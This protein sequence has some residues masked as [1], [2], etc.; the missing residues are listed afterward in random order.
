MTDTTDTTN[1]LRAA[2]EALTNEAKRRVDAY[3]GVVRRHIRGEVTLMEREFAWGAAMDAI[4]AI[5]A[6]E[7]PAEKHCPSAQ[8]PAPSAPEQPANVSAKKPSHLQQWRSVIEHGEIYRDDQQAP[9]QPND[10]DVI[11]PNCTHQF[12]AIPEQVQRLML[13][14]GFEPPFTAAPK[15]PSAAAPQT[16]SFVQPVPDKCDRITW[17]GRYYHLPLATSAA[18]VPVSGLK[19]AV[20][21]VKHFGNPIPQ[22]WYAAA[23]E[24]L[25]DTQPTSAA[26]GREV[27][28]Y[29]DAIG[30][31]GQEY[32]RRF[33]PHAHPLPALFRWEELWNAMRAATSTGGA[34]T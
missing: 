19:L 20:I 23:R 22:Q 27:L 4:D 15:Q 26:A 1:D 32:M 7:Q 8:Q 21:G 29:T 5:A 12:R 16:T 34:E 10:T 2:L 9:E 6:T 17:R 31:A 13:A 11:C 25:A 14:A 30:K 28:T 33:E 3:V 18:E 24:L